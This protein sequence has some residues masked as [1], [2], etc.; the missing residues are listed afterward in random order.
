MLLRYFVVTLICMTAGWSFSTPS[1]DAHSVLSKTGSQ[2]TFLREF[3]FGGI[4]TFEWLPDGYKLAVGTNTGV[5]IYDINSS[6][7]MPRRL[8]GY[9]GKVQRLYLNSSG[10]FLATQGDSFDKQVHILDIQTGQ[11]VRTLNDIDS[12][13]PIAF[14]SDQASL[15]IVNNQAVIQ[16]IN[17]FS[18]SVKVLFDD[19]D[20]H[21]VAISPNGETLVRSVLLDDQESRHIELWDIA[22]ETKQSTIPKSLSNITFSPDGQKFSVVLENQ[23]IEIYD[24]RTGDLVQRLEIENTD[25]IEPR[26]TPHITA[27]DFNPDATLLFT[28]NDAGALRRWNLASE[29]FEVIAYL[30][31]DHGGVY[32][33]WLNLAVSP[34]AKS[35]ALGDN[36][37]LLLYDLSKSSTSSLIVDHDLPICD[38]D[39]SADDQ[40]L[41]G[42]SAGDAV[43]VWNVTTGVRLGLRRNF[44]PRFPEIPIRWRCLVNSFAVHPNG[45]M[46]A[47]ASEGNTASVSVTGEYYHSI[48]EGHEERIVSVVFS[49]DGLL[50]A[51]G[52]E[53]KTVRIWDVSTGKQVALLK[54]HQA[55]IQVLSF[56][57]DSV[58]LSSGDAN[59]EIRLWN[60]TTGKPIGKPMYSS[61]A[62]SSI[63]FSPDKSRVISGNMQGFLYVWD[64]T[65]GDLIT[66]I[67]AHVSGIWHIV[68]SSDGNSFVSVGESAKLWSISEQRVH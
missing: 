5:W 47:T 26:F 54:G 1:P 50:L 16:S 64:V 63:A 48:Y 60:A 43:Q 7:N 52:S 39:F 19:Q 22:T 66:S 9:K 12:W 36:S 51:S 49:P 23:H 13:L 57:R 30:D 40:V 3:G 24:A 2:V 11:L 34:N 45:R 25:L 56:S 41:F 44:W 10:T 14:R 46:T 20:M 32:A 42:Y 8:E 33:Y 15:I 31:D 4:N 53:D 55:S 28:A 61:T 35:I 62:I 38:V 29:T 37:S 59:G 67:S 21:V 18:G 68:F 17:V 6:D 65:T 27:I 58:W